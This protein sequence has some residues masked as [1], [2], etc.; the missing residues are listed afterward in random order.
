MLGRFVTL[1]AIIAVASIAVGS[2]A[3]R[4]AIVKAPVASSAEGDGGEA[5][6][7]WTMQPR[8][9]GGWSAGAN[10]PSG[11]VR[12]GR[13]SDSHF[14][15]DADVGGT[16]I[17][18]M[19]DSGASVVALTRRDAEAI[20]IDVDRLPVVGKAQTAGGPVDMRA[21]MLDSVDVDGIE[22]R[23]VQAAVVDA[24]MGV[25]LLGQ[26]YLSRLGG[27]TIEGDTMTLR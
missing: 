5:D 22:V 13:A 10:A 12:L 26:S 27:V 14:Y 9:R 19:V 24:D 18:M 4:D 11:E 16:S 20:G 17:R 25:S 2:R 7:N 6:G 1:A 21:V 15:A 3:S 23:R 8:S